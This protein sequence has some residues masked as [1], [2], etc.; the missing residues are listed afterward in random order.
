MMIVS[1]TQTKKSIVENIAG[2]L[3]SRVHQYSQELAISFYFYFYTPA[4]TMKM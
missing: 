1:Y 3:K 4:H 2:A